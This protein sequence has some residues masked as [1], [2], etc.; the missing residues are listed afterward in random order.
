MQ[1]LLL[2]KD[3]GPKYESIFAPSCGTTNCLINEVVQSFDKDNQDLILVGEMAELTSALLNRHRGRIDKANVTEE[4][5]HVLISC[6]VVRRICEISIDQ[7]EAESL[8]KL[9]KYGWA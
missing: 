3:S 1:E 5:A 7:L 6:E 4:L 2:L 8:K 9:Q